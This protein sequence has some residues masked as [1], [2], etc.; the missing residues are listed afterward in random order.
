MVS[1]YF[2]LVLFLAALPATAK[3]S[4]E[5]PPALR[6]ELAQYD[7]AGNSP[8]FADRLAFRRTLMARLLKDYPNSPQVHIRHVRF[9]ERQLTGEVPA[10]VEQ[11]RKRLDAHPD[12]SL[13]LYLYGYA[14]IGRKTDEA[15]ALLE[16]SIEK[17]PGFVWPHLALADIYGY[18]R[19]QNKQELARHVEAFFAGCP[20]S[21]DN[22]AL[23][24]PI[25]INSAE[26]RRKV[27]AAVRARLEHET[28]PWFLREYPNLWD[29]EFKATPPAK[30]DE[31]RK[32]IADDLKRMDAAGST[33]LPM[34]N[35]MM[36]GCRY[37]NDK[38]G[39]RRVEERILR[40]HAASRDAVQVVTARWD[41]EHPR[42]APGDP[43][44]KR[45]AHYRAQLQANSE[46]VKRWPNDFDLLRNRFGMMEILGDEVPANE[47]QAAA[48]RTLAALKENPFDSGLPPF[49]MRVA[50]AYAKRG[51]ALDRVE[52]LVEQ[53]FAEFD[54]EEKR[55][56]A[57]DRTG[58]TDQKMRENNR[59]YLYQQALSVL[60][61]L[62]EKTKQPAKAREAWQR[63]EKELPRAT[64][65]A[66]Q[67]WHYKAQLGVIEGRKLDALT[68]Y[69]SSISARTVAL[70]PGVKDDIAEHM[71]RLWKELGGT[72][73]AW[74]DRPPGK[75]VL[76]AKEA[77]DWKKPEKPMPAFALE[78]LE[79][80]TWKLAQ[81]EGK[82]V[83]INVWA[84]WCGP[85]VAEHP[86]VQKLYDK[87]KDRSEV[88]LL[89]FNVDFQAGEIVP[90]MKKNGYTFP[91]LLAQSF[92][93]DMLDGISIPRIWLL[94]AKGVLRLEQIGF[95][96]NDAEW[97][98]KTIAGLEKLKA[99]R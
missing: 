76:E 59:R 29:L 40:D 4:C 6:R 53:G 88:A 30:H 36:R 32:R 44:E 93:R 83:F 34:L 3:T 82:A 71:K 56:A 45:K 60:L 14:L 73:E 1:G 58:G 57:D 96:P 37:M 86:A 23:Y 99:G 79:G 47:L 51:I 31:V 70:A 65:N 43:E 81:F 90:Y 63:F 41:V 68:Y 78:D 17:D 20:D 46:W 19:L 94:D 91:V 54:K 98:V 64:W 5:A 49:S 22:E 50:R 52:P 26:L 11:Y 27:A 85:C 39:L 33:E 69:Q 80:K 97:I 35:A 38:D 7:L 74:N 72:D 62:Y 28:D 8:V 84:T 61:D 66:S 48:A 55:S 25:R 9:I 42:P 12:D 77:G 95:N 67:Y 13:S 75:S 21:L 15:L 24:A 18:G 87:L 89:T 92:V 16:K 10:M 2:A